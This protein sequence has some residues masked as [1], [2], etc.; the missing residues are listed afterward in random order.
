[1]VAGEEAGVD[2]EAVDVDADDDKR[3]ATDRLSHD[4]FSKSCGDVKGLRRAL[5]SIRLFPVEL[6][7]HTR[8]DPNFDQAFKRYIFAIPHIPRPFCIM[9]ISIVVLLSISASVTCFLTPTSFHR[10]P[11]FLRN[12]EAPSSTSLAPT[13][14]EA[15]RLRSEA[16]RMRLE[17]EHMEM[18]V[19]LEKI[20][21]MEGKLQ[22]RRWMEKHTDEA[23]KLQDQIKSLRKRLQKDNEDDPSS[24]ASSKPPSTPALT[25]PTAPPEESSPASAST[26]SP[27]SLTP[28]IAEHPLSAFDD[29]DLE[30]YLPVAQKIQAEMPDADEETQLAA[31]RAAPEL[32]EYFGKKIHRILVEPME[33]VQQLED[34]KGQYLSSSSRKEKDQLKRQIDK[35]EQKVEEDGPF[36][37]SDSI[38]LD[39]PPMPEVEYRARLDVLEDFPVSLRALYAKRTG[40]SDAS[41]LRLAIEL[42]HYSSQLQILEQVK[43]IAPLGDELMAQTENAVLSL[44]PGVREHLAISAG[45]DPKS[46]IAEIIHGLT[47][48][49][50]TKESDGSTMTARET[51]ESLAFEDND[52]YDIEY[53]DRSRF[54]EEF[55]PSVARMEG[56]QPSIEDVER[57]ATQV[58]D[59]KAFMVTSKP[60]TV[61]GGYYVRGENRIEDDEFGVELV[62]RLRASLEKSDLK[63]K[64]QFFYIVDPAPPADEDVELGY[65]EQPLLLVTG[66]NQTLFYDNT[67]PL[68]K[69]G[70][71]FLGAL[72]SILY[73][74]AA[75]EMQPALL[76]QIE[77]N[78][79][80]LLDN[81]VPIAL[82][83]L[84][85]Q[86]M[87]ELGHKII[88]VRDNF[89]T[90]WP[91]LVPS[92]Q[93]GLLGAITPLASPPPNLKSMFDFGMAGPLFGYAT[94]L[95]F[96]LT[97]LE[98]TASADAVSAA[99]FP[100]L[101]AFLLHSSAL[102]GGMTEYFLG[103]GI[104]SMGVTEDSIVA[105]H[106]FAVAGFAGLVSN[107]VALL[108]LGRTYILLL[109]FSDSCLDTEDSLVLADTDGGRVA[110]AM[111]GRR[112]AFVVN[113]FSALLICAAGVFGLDE[114]RT[115]LIYILFSFLWQ[116]DPETPAINEVEELDFIRGG[117]AIG[118][119]LIVFLTILPIL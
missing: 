105:L 63:D 79:P 48:W 107:A 117:A 75:C 72:A 57:F 70:V 85:T 84:G 37:Y 53:V 67:L 9:M 114:A 113:I 108:P 11:T 26:S 40:A 95:G 16:A 109:I 73:A 61:M 3:L 103:R 77:A 49:K 104:L 31:F 46:S 83:L 10:P 78:P 116:R 119:A 4:L 54:V 52:S 12:A 118:A 8:E 14:S 51:I 36:N 80:L 96:L 34:L 29:E 15:D 58:V 47:D 86:F 45:L 71:T 25:P 106:P 92:I 74:S 21:S 43:Y 41:D 102:G 39:T 112:G 101:P 62:E 13:E 44:P 18:S 28:V 20:A 50:M 76:A 17:A 23:E 19:T 6:R 24:G 88:A 90:G 87:H 69:V 82:P 93:T 33:E 27:D 35:L 38:F 1:M 2:V 91:T 111:F 66:V 89:R 30:V 7:L 115:L 97:G 98:M 94:S 100:G 81:L 65:D 55:F 56:S 32:Q 68:T 5:S 60:E 59:K 64:L 42:E 99:S 22:D 110:L